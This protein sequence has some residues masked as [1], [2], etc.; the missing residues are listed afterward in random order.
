M[1]YCGNC[2][3][4]KD[5]REDVCPYCGYSPFGTKAKQAATAKLSGVTNYFNE[6]KNDPIRMKQAQIVAICVAVVA[7]VALTAWGL[8]N[9]SGI[10]GGSSDDGNIYDGH[11]SYTDDT[12]SDDNDDDYV[13]S[14][15]IGS[16]YVFGSYEQDNNS[17]NGKEDIVW[18]VISEDGYGNYLLLSQKILAYRPFSD[19]G[20]SATW[21]TSSLR[22]WLNDDFYNS[23]FSSSEKALIQSEGHN[24]PDNTSYNVS[25]GATTTDKV[26]LLSKSEATSLL[27]TSQRKCSPTKKAA[28]D[29]YGD[30][31]SYTTGDWWWLRSPGRSTTTMM[32]VE[33]D[34]TIRV[35]GVSNSGTKT[36]VRPAIWVKLG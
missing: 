5:E 24:T 15:S 18:I 22:T 36:G 11:G 19:S 8:S 17:S 34:G 12:D 4:Y 1:P 26:F 21:A 20:A 16:T 9:S 6:L 31:S 10:G 25:G 30:G 27:S 32:I 29:A 14:I 13:P 2:G 28:Y 3:A 7:V 35:E 33:G 23:A